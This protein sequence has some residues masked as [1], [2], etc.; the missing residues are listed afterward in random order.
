MSVNPVPENYPRIIP[1]IS[2]HDCEAAI[3]FY[4]RA[5]GATE[6]TRFSDDEGK[7]MH[8]E[9]QLGDSVLMIGPPMDGETHTLH[10]MVYVN[11]CDAV[12]ARM[13]DAGGT[14]KKEPED[15]FWGDRAGQITD[16]FGNEW[17]VAS[18]VEDVAEDEMRNRFRAYQEQMQEAAE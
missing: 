5:L 13:R 16:P 15:Q 11:D 4:K 3:E 10:A 8:A 12:F 2:V 14:P 17:F 9:L 1:G 18:H 6:R 7:V